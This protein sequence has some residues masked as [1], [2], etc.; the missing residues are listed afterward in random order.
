MV[1]RKADFFVLARVACKRWFIWGWKILEIYGIIR[2]VF[3]VTLISVF[4]ETTREH[5]QIKGDKI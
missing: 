3:F 4:T 5:N 2:V 1:I